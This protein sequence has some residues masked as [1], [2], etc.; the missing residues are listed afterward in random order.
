M[1]NVAKVREVIKIV[2]TI[3]ISLTDNELNPILIILL[4]AL[5][6]MEKEGEKDGTSHRNEDI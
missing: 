2:D 1:A 5:K 6:R 3:G 4:N